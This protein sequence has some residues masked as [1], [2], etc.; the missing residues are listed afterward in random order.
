MRHRIQDRGSH[1]ATGANGEDCGRSGTFGSR[2]LGQ[3]S[4]PTPGSNPGSNSELNA[5]PATPF[6]RADCGHSTSRLG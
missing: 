3:P 4:Y 6:D 1:R 5:Y 2:G